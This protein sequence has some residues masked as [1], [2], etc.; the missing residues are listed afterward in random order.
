MAIRRPT[1]KVDKDNGKYYARITIAGKRKRFTF[2]MSHRDSEKQLSEVLHDLEVK[3][4][5]T[6]PA[7]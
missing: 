1:L 2:T 4:T 3:A 7:A 5:T 6:V